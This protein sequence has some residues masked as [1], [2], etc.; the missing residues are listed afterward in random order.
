M[1]LNRQPIELRQPNATLRG[2]LTGDGPPL[3]LLHGG[4]GC[5]DYFSGTAI[6]ARLAERFT[7]YTYDQRGTKRSPSTGPFSI[8]TNVADLNALLDHVGASPATLIGHS[9]GAVLACHYAAAFPQRVARIILLSPAGIRPGW[10]AAFDATLRHRFKQL[11]RADIERI[12]AA[13]RVE[14]DADRRAALYLERFNVALPAYVDPAHRACAPRLVD[15]NREANVRVNGSLAELTRTR[16]W[17]A[18]LSGFS[19]PVSVIHGRSDPIPWSVV[20]DYCE[21]FPK[22]RVI[23]LEGVGHFPWLEDEPTTIRAIDAAVALN[24]Q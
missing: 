21:V 20:D 4:P 2:L 11:Q 19:A 8:Q 16:D 22:A 9:S 12:D 13:I 23:P 7:V 24:Q 15:F 1:P 6:E 3:F 10:R 18:R 17:E 5:A 14:H